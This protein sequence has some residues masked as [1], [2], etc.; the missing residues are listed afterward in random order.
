MSALSTTPQVALP[1]EEN[2]ASLGRVGRGRS[3]R[4]LN[5]RKRCVNLP[6]QR[7][8]KKTASGLLLPHSS[9]PPS[10]PSASPI[11]L[12]TTPV[13]QPSHPSKDTLKRTRSFTMSVPC[14]SVGSIMGPGGSIMKTLRDRSQCQIVLQQKAEL[15]P[16]Q[17]RRDVNLT[18]S[19]SQ[20]NAARKLIALCI[21]GDAIRDSG[22]RGKTSNRMK[23]MLRRTRSMPARWMACGQRSN[24]ISISTK[25]PDVGEAYCKPPS[26]PIRDNALDIAK[27]EEEDGE[28]D[29]ELCGFFSCEEEEEGDE[30]NASDESVI[31]SP[32]KK[33]GKLSSEEPGMKQL[34]GRW[35]LARGPPN[36]GA[37]GFKE[38]FRGR[39]GSRQTT[40]YMKR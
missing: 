18:G 14:A 1:F 2:T 6:I 23:N 25:A 10:A 31:C 38:S 29:D 16:G 28:E 7:V 26:P 24:A 8:L 20:I 5:W 19:E 13:E 27:E 39:A 36:A 15:L 17:R 35:R 40:A 33:R 32:V 4:D 12:P 11:L 22:E 37:R 34:P 9:V 30:E 21:A 3:S